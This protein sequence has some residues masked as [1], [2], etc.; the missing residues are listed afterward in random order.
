MPKHN[1]THASG[2]SSLLP[3]RE[4]QQVLQ[5]ATLHRH[6][7][8]DGPFVLVR[9]PGVHPYSPAHQASFE[10]IRRVTAARVC[11]LG[12]GTAPLGLWAAR[13]GAHVTAWHDSLAE[14]LTTEATFAAN[15]QHPPTLICDREPPPALAGSCDLALL[16]LPRGRELQARLLQMAEWVLVPGGKLVFT[17][18]KNEGFG[19]ALAEAKARFGQAGVVARKGGHHAAL[20]YRSGNDLPDL[21]DSCSSYPIQVAGEETELVGC[22]GAFA[23]DRLD[24]GAASLIAGMEIDAG[25]SV[26]DLGCGTG[27]VGLAALRRGAHVTGTDVS[28]AAVAS[29]R[30]TWAA[31][32]FPD[33]VAHLS[34]GAAALLSGTVDTVVTNP[35]FHRGRDRDFEVAQLFVKEAARVLAPGGNL[36]LVAN[37]FLDYAK[38]L[39]RDFKGIEVIWHDS[40]FRVWYGQR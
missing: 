35:P 10:A 8:P 21:D 31:N 29:S 33:A 24:F 1:R 22:T 4:A 34:V 7:L 2:S 20:A 19:S 18:A 5:W 12:P 9:L 17:G 16:R 40:R 13:A 26:L 37:S 11:L 27:L 14:A 36:Y 32:G 30:R 6:V 3:Q 39:A 38:W 25:A 15:D 28:A 23:T